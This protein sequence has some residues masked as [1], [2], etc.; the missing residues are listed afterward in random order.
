MG[1]DPA[2][3]KPHVGQEIAT[4]VSTWQTVLLGAVAGLTIFLGLPM[5]RVQ[6]KA[7]PTKTFLNGFSAGIVVFLFFDILANATDPLEAAVPDHHWGVVAG[8]GP[9]CAIARTAGLLGRLYLSRLR[10]P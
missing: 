1:S 2:A 7:R 10:R 8:I 4:A 6:T 5:G 3:A 9:V